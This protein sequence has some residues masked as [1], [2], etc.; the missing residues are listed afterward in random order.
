MGT[1]NRSVNMA[2][3]AKNHATYL[4]SAMISGLLHMH[5]AD[6]F[7]LRRAAATAMQRMRNG[8]RRWTNNLKPLS[9]LTVTVFIL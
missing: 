8:R 2:N 1:L 9:V 6:F 7:H 5:G 3:I 4:T